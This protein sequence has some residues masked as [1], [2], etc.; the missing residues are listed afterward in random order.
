MTKDMI[1]KSEVKPLNSQEDAEIITLDNT[2][3]PENGKD[4]S[5][6]QHNQK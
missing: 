2:H 1:N 4:E 3:E 5:F 6:V